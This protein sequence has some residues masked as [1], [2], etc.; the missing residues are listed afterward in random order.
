LKNVHIDL[1]CWACF[2]LGVSAGTA[3]AFCEWLPLEATSLV[4]MGLAIL[5]AIP[6]MYT[7][8]RKPRSEDPGVVLPLIEGLVATRTRSS[9]GETR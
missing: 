8:L 9:S 3:N 4:A 1:G 7:L 6:P 2:M 5:A